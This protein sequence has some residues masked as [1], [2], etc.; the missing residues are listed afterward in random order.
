V[1]AQTISNFWLAFEAN[2]TI[3]PVI[4]KI[5]LDHAD[6]P[7]VL[8]QLKSIFEIDAGDVLLTSAKSG[9][10]VEAVM[11]AVLARVPP[12]PKAAEKSGLQALLFDS[13]YDRH[14]GVVM[15]WRLMKGEQRNNKENELSS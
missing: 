8:S 3:V 15:L 5:D 2:L 1:Q 9:L 13:W 4:N 14:V 12:P 7:N 11:D 10:N 6:V